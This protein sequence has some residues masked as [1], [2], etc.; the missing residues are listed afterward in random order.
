MPNL[1][2]R[3][4]RKNLTDAERAIWR[5]LRLRQIGGQKF[6]RQQPIGPYIVDFVCHEKKLIVEIDGGQHAELSV[7]D[8]DAKRTTWLETQGFHILRFWNN[9]VLKE[10]DAVKE[11]IWNALLLPPPTPSPARGEGKET[12]QE[13]GG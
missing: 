12:S 8:H 5:Y 13:S 2:A 3:E 4:L 1:K 7:Y 6:R 10:T 11:V 9:Q